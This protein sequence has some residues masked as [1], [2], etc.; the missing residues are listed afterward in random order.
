MLYVTVIEA[1]LSKILDCYVEMEYDSTIAKTE[2]EKSS[3]PAFTAQN[4]FPI[5]CKQGFV[6]R[7]NE[8][9][10]LR[11]HNTVAEAT[12]NIDKF[13]NSEKSIFS[14]DW[15]KLD[16][17][18]H[19]LSVA[20]LHLYIS[21]TSQLEEDKYYIVARDHYDELVELVLGL[22][23]DREYVYLIKTFNVDQL[24]TAIITLFET[25]GQGVKLL[26]ELVKHDVKEQK[27]ENEIFRAD[28]PATKAVSKY[29][30]VVGNLFLKRCLESTIHYAI[31]NPPDFDVDLNQLANLEEEEK[32]K[33]FVRE[34]VKKF[35]NAR[36]KLY[37][38]GQNK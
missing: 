13:T 26:L 25:N 28:S 11:K 15:Y 9:H 16:I 22:R 17:K 1:R 37:P 29:F 8:H 24:L 20:E 19:D 23:I 5:F 7:L 32:R 30:R 12:I 2:L 3:T 33:A 36:K 21:F 18:D 14:D 34:C 10:R 38:Y 31:N 6:V 27:S 4:Y 35:L